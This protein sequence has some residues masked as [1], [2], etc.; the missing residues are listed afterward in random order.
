MNSSFLRKASIMAQE[1]AQ[2]STKR[3]KPDLNKIQPGMEVEDT[4]HELG[5]SDMSKP[6]VTYV[7]RDEQGQVKYLVV[8]KGLL[9][10]K[11]ILVPAKR[12]KEVKQEPED[13]KGPGE[14]VIETHLEDE[15]ELA[16]R[17][18]DILSD[19]EEGDI[20][21]EIQEAMPTAEGLEALEAESKQEE[22]KQPQ[23]S[24]EAKKEEQESPQEHAAHPR[25][26]QLLQNIGPGFLAGMSGNDATAVTSYAINGAT[27]G[28]GQLWL[29]VLT[30]PMYQAVE[31]SCSKIGRTTRVG[32]DAILRAHYSRWVAVLAA[33]ILITT[34][35]ALIAGNLV[36]IGSGFE[37]ITGISWVWFVIPAALFLWYI[38][39][40]SNFNFMKKIFIVMSAAFITY[41]IT[42]F[43][44]GADWKTVLISSF[45]PQINF[46]FAAI[47]AALALLGATISPY[48]MYWQMR[49]EIEEKRAGTMKQQYRAAGID[50]ASGTI[51]GNLVSYFVIIT[52]ASTLF[53]HHQSILTALDAANSL[54]PLVGPFAKYLFAIG[55]IGAALIAIP[56]MSASSAYAVADTFGW[57]AGLSEQPWQAEGFYIVLTVSLL[58]GMAFALLRIDP[59]KLSFYANVFTGVLAP[60]MVMYLMAIGNSGKIMGEHKLGWLTNFFLAVTALVLI[61]GSVLFF[62]GLATGQ[63]G[64]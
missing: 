29:M 48:S 33:L 22:R 17:G 2:D 9:F 21:A 23:P 49:A 5:E 13:K 4:A 12:I 55:L 60:I 39:V 62:Y 7:I 3:Q 46:N 28:Y 18:L 37:L 44:S 35:V 41:I 50:V 51:G 61:A 11:M 52:T 31:Y 32:L 8:S 26:L 54:G 16:K 53:V 30:T 27:A 14:V 6:R 45:V 58:V 34:N 59:I 24:G 56:I 25:I 63:G 1:H 47:S 10:K 64:S 38:T 42:A 15:Q 40:F 36:A 19:I 43:V 57:P 20:L